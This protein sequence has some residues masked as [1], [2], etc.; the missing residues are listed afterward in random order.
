MAK[1]KILNFFLLHLNY[2]IA[3]MKPVN[4]HWYLSKK[5]G[6]YIATK[7]FIVVFILK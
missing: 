3:W 7:A 2:H 5:Y 4:M 6:L 1:S